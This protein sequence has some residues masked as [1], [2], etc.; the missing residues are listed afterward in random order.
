[1][2]RKSPQTKVNRDY[3]RKALSARRLG[4]NAT[5]TYCPESRPEALIPKSKPRIC[6]KCQRKHQGKS[7]ID[8]HHVGG[9]NNHAA[10]VP[11]PVNDHR[12]RL[13]LQQYKWPSKTL[14][15]IDGSPLLAIAACI[16]GFIDFLEYCIDE[17]L[18][19]T[20]VVLEDLDACLVEK[21]GPRWWV[22]TNTEQPKPKENSN[23]EK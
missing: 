22:G 20:V 15:N 7:A 21:L 9:K 8:Q 2:P 19:W 11:V 12:A 10:T 5:C 3:R 23:E 6:A 1:M 13:N 4:K 17:F 14:R 18:R 16:R